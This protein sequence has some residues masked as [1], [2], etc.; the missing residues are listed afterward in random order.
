[1]RNIN[2]SNILEIILLLALIGILAFSI[3]FN[4]H[5]AA[6]VADF[7]IICGIAKILFGG[8]DINIPLYRQKKKELSL[9]VA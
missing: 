4:F 5:S 6:R 2:R 8:G 7:F 3:K 1:M 9:A